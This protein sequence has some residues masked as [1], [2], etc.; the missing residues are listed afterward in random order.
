MEEET[1]LRE[2]ARG[3]WC[4]AA[5]SLRTDEGWVRVPAVGPRPLCDADRERVRKVLRELPGR[6]VTLWT[7]LGKTGGTAGSDG[8]P[9]GKSGSK[10]PLNLGVDALMRELVEVATSWEDQVRA[11]A[12]LSHREI[13]RSD[14]HALMRACDVLIAHTDALLALELS[15]IYRS[16][17]LADKR[18]LPENAVIVKYSTIAGWAIYSVPL[19]GTDGAVEFLNLAHR[20]RSTLLETRAPQ[21]L[22]VRCSTCGRR[23]LERYDGYAGLED[24]AT[25]TT[26]GDVYS[27]QRYLLLLREEHEFAMARKK[28]RGQRQ[29]SPRL[30]L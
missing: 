7:H 23:T 25:C 6:Y 24:E 30:P 2:C 28:L 21:H 26:C 15:R 4:A 9:P 5:R 14:H 18:R 22:E 19:S 27:N 13:P 8:K 11:V 10:V 29:R 16:R 12:R 1:E 3:A 20:V 17:D